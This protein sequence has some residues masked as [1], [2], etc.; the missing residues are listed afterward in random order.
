MDV[1]NIVAVQGF[2]AAKM[3][4]VNLFETERFFCDVYCFEPGQ[5][6]ALHGHAREDKVYVVLS[7]RGQ[8]TIGDETRELVA[9]EA[10]L[11][12]AGVEHGVV[13]NS[14]ERL[15]VLAFMAP[16]PGKGPHA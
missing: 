1:K 15:T 12:P 5:T 14:G 6:Q 9:N 4:K 10:T 11:A 8:F 2:S 16:R 3:Q 7:G 13:N